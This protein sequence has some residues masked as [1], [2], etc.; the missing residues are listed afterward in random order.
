MRIGII[1]VRDADY[2]PNRRL[3]EAAREQG[4]D[5][6]LVHP[7][8]LLPILEQ[9]TPELAGLPDGKTLDVV[10]PRQGATVGEGCLPL[11]RHF[12]MMGIRVINNLEA[13]LLARNKMLCLQALSGA[14]LSVPGSCFVNIDTEF[15]TAVER[16]GGYPVVVKAVTGRQGEGVILAESERDIKGIR[17]AFVEGGRG[18]VV[19]HFI[20]PMG[21][22]DIRVLVLG[23][24]AIAAMSLHPREGDFRANFHLSGQSRPIILTTALEETA[25]RAAQA[26]GLEIAGVDLM[27]EQEGCSYVVE[28]NYTP[29]FKGLEEATGQDIAGK[30]VQYVTVGADRTKA[31]SLSVY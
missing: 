1:T 6:V 18:L 30:I 29:G 27:V 15:S 28:V 16:L 9:G 17:S 31:S 7:Y 2:H 3:M 10:L 23:G 26:V 21:R 19:Q 22:Q 14:G 13:I 4:H 25:I 12:R 24:Q 8:H 20:P 5:L 11:I